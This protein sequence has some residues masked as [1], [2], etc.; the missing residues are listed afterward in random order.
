MF[1][2]PIDGSGVVQQE[3]KEANGEKLAPC[4]AEL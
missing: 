4:G 1:P 2:V 3:V